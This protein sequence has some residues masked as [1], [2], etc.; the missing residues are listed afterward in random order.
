MDDIDPAS[1][2]QLVQKDDPFLCHEFLT[3]LENSGSV[4]LENGWHPH[5]CL[6]YEN[7]QLVAAMP[8]Y[9]K[10]HSRGEYVFD[11]QWADAYHRAGLQYY[12]KWLTAIPF[13]PCQ[14]QRILIRPG[15]LAENI[16][17]LFLDQIKQLSHE[18]SISSYHCLFPSPP[19]TRPLSA[20]LLIRHGIQFQWRNQD[21]DNFEHFLQHFSSRHRKNVKRE[22]TQINQMGITLQRIPGSHISHDM[23][24]AFYR[25]YQNTYFKNGQH[26]YLTPEFFHLIIKQMPQKIMLTAAY[27]DKQLVAAALYFVGENTLFG[28]YWGCQQEFNGLH[29]EACYY[30][31]I[32]YCLENKLQHFDSGAQGEHKIARG[33]EPVDTYSLHW[34]ADQKFSGIIK[35]FLQR[36]KKYMQEYKAHCKKKL[37]F[38]N[39]SID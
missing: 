17:K 30:Q 36:E 24:T 14:G 4:T 2:N 23:I 7:G 5:H 11:F 9:L 16:I 3:A 29:F 34:L 31:G 10:S 8:L 20:D 21:Y 27:L 38:K 6:M 18:H 26:P 19:Q 28:R 39:T 15:L 13:T 35:D 1:W 37:P 22:R 25:F 32:E 12:P 33:F